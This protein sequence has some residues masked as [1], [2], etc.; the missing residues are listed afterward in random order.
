VRA[1]PTVEEGCGAAQMNLDD[2]RAHIDQL[3]ADL[4][5][6]RFHFAD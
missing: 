3:I 5:V 1:A 2:M 4:R 6:T